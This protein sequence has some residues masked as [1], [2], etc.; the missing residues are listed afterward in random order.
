MRYERTVPGWY[1]ETA[2]DKH[3]FRRFILSF[4]GSKSRYTGDSHSFEAFLWRLK[5]EICTAAPFFLLDIL[6]LRLSTIQRT[7]SAVFPVT[8]SSLPAWALVLIFSFSLISQSLGTQFV[9]NA[10]SLSLISIEYYRKCLMQ[11]IFVDSRQFFSRLE[12]T[13]KGMALS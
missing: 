13:F 4:L 9:S 1:L 6:R 11:A 8:K 5:P 3:R 7:L 10:S 2:Y 12:G